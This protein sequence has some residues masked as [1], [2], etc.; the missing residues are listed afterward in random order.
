MELK[1][2]GSEPSMKGPE[3]YITGTV[4]IDPLN[5]RPHRRGLPWRA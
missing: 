3:E 1:R 4:R 2:V 5:S